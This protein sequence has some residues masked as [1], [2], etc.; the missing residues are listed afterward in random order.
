MAENNTPNGKFILIV[1]D[2]PGTSE[3]ETQRLETLGLEIRRAGSAEETVGILKS[4][5]PEL[6]L[7]D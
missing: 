1:E 2:D 7:L 4:A 5:T 3:L 6:M